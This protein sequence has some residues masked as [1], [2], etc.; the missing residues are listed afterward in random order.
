[1]T[2]ESSWHNRRIDQLENRTAVVC[3]VVSEA[4][5]EHYGRAHIHVIGKEVARLRYTK[6]ADTGAGYGNKRARDFRL[7]ISVVPG[8]TVAFDRSRRADRF[9]EE[10]RVAEQRECWRAV[11][12]GCGNHVQDLLRDRVGHPIGQFLGQAGNRSDRREA[13][14]QPL[15]SPYAGICTAGI[16]GYV[17]RWR[18]VEMDAEQGG[19]AGSGD[20][21]VEINIK[22]ADVAVGA[23]HGHAVAVRG[24][25]LA[26]DEMIAF[27]GS[28]DEQSISLVDPFALEV[29]KKFRKGC[30]V[31]L[32]LLHIRRL[33]R[34][35]GTLG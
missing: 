28:E 4:G 12:I 30:I 16:A 25:R 34:T 10:V 1:M 32:K 23:G 5:Q 6:M 22:L 19:I 15:E 33:A 26:A 35:E 17:G 21:L 27:V 2:A 14:N 18:V 13:R 11:G 29:G 24:T 20:E 3:V 8:K 31:V 9:E 7:I